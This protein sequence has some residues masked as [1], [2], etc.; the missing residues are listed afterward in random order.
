VDDRR[1]AARREATALLT[2]LEEDQGEDGGGRRVGLTGAPG[3]GKST[4]LDVLVRRLRADGVS[5][6]VIAVDPSSRRTG[7][8]LLGDRLRVRASAGDRGVFFRSLAAREQLG[9]L[10]VG[11]RA[12]VVVLASVFDFVLVETV[13]VGQS[14]SEVAELVDT[15]VYVA[16]PGA[17]DLLQF[18][19]AGLLELP[20][21]FVVN[22]ADLGPAAE[23]TASEIEAGI[24]LAERDAGG[25][26]PPVV[27][28]SARDGTGAD[29][30]VDALEAH[31]AHLLAGAALA[32]RR[33]HGRDAFVRN[34]L[35]ARYGT[36]GLEAL[37]G[38]DALAER[39]CGEPRVPG[40]ALAEVLGGEIE[41][42][43]RQRARGRQT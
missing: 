30:L 36:F 7:G 37:G 26:T 14:E 22:K 31:H 9:G 27:L 3:T 28:V 35:L 8:A 20:D 41:Q 33:R 1:V 40:F 39:L 18:M 42:A 13:G 25:W 32:A 19:K 34:T 43:L 5:V 38:A 23:R 11:A 10:A 4:L 21:V 29:A 16:Q 17:G 15:L 6:G 24:G 2:A 12:A